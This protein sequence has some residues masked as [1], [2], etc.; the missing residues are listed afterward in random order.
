MANGEIV[1][2]LECMGC[3]KR[4]GCHEEKFDTVVISETGLC[5]ECFYSGRYTSIVNDCACREAYG[6]RCGGCY[7]WKELGGKRP[8]CYE[9][10]IGSFVCAMVEVV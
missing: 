8:W 9:R 3:G 2:E 4:V 6:G 1:E 10:T 5:V 7:A